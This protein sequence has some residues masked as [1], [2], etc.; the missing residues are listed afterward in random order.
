M[1]ICNVIATKILEQVQIITINSFNFKVYARNRRRRGMF[2]N[3]RI[4]KLI[5]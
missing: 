1:P 3:G 2:L 5:Q 4:Q